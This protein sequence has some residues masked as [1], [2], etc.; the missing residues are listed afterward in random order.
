MLPALL[1][2]AAF[3]LPPNPTVSPLWGPGPLVNFGHGDEQADT[4]A[5]AHL[6]FGAACTLTGYYVGNHFFHEPKK[7]TL[8]GAIICT[9]LVAVRLFVFHAPQDALQQGCTVMV[10]CKPRFGLS[11]GYGPEL[12][13]GLISGVVP[14]WGVAIPLLVF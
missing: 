12:R 7:G 3:Y 8:Y 6:W 2:A 10:I 1:L 5:L 4:N 9:T 11:A 14:I 13:A